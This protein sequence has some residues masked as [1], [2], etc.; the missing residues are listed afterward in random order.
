METT[1]EAD[2]WSNM[3]ICIRLLPELPFGPDEERNEVVLRRALLSDHRWE[4]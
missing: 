4:R 1:G 2:D 3:A